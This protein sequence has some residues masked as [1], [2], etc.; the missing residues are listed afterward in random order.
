M[1]WLCWQLVVH[2]LFTWIRHKYLKIL[3][4][5]LFHFWKVWDFRYFIWR[6]Y[7]NKIQLFSIF[8]HFFF[9]FWNVRDFGYFIWRV[10]VNKTQCMSIFFHFF[11]S[12]LKCSTFWISY[13]SIF[14]ISKMF[15]N[16]LF[17]VSEMFEIL[18]ILFGG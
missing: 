11:F 6:V 15:E 12:F 3:F 18:D 2:L 7:V 9:H 16:H 5:F 4:Y 10:H 17:F 14:F 8:F 13:L 1:S